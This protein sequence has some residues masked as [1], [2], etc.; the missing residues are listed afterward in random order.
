VTGADLFRFL[1][2]KHHLI[3]HFGAKTARSRA[4]KN[5]AGLFKNSS[6]E[7]LNNPLFYL[8]LDWQ[9]KR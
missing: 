6:R 7:F 5:V 9:K 2:D 8:F 3:G 4:E 1:P